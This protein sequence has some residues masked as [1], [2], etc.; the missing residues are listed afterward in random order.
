MIRLI[1]VIRIENT[2][3]VMISEICLKFVI[4][5]NHL[6]IINIG[7]VTLSLG[8]TSHGL[9]EFLYLKELGKSQEKTKYPKNQKDHSDEIRVLFRLLF[10]QTVIII[11]VIVFRE[12]ILS[13]KPVKGSRKDRDD[14]DI[15][16]L[17]VDYI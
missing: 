2:D 1:E 12:K 6:F 5:L 15:L 10:L 14:D 11:A 3:V 7:E 16:R 13:D 9:I 17:T 4:F 8:K